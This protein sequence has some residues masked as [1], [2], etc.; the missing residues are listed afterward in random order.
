MSLYRIN[1]P[2]NYMKRVPKIKKDSKKEIRVFKNNP[3]FEK[4]LFLI[5]RLQLIFSRHMDTSV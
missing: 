5:F 3:A 2:G 1:G 4:D